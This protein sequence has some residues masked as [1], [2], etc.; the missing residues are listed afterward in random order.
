MYRASIFGG[1][2][3]AGAIRSSGWY[4][5]ANADQPASGVNNRAWTGEEI[6]YCEPRQI[7]FIQ[8]LSDP[9]EVCRNQTS[10]DE[11][12]VHHTSSASALRSRNSEFGSFGRHS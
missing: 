5:R 9:M 7:G 11:A 1:Q 6:A 12:T 4:E 8:V 2:E 10:W 3:P